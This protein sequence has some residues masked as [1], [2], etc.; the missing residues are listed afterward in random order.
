[1][2]QHT[3]RGASG[4]A[5]LA[6]LAILALLGMVTYLVSERN[7]HTWYL[8]PDEGRLVVMKGVFLP[9]GRQAF[10][11]A[12]P[13]LAQAYAPVVVPPGKAVP[14]ERDFSDQTGL[15]QALYDD[16]AG[17]AREDI[18]S[19]DPARLERALGYVDRADHLTGISQAQRQDLAALRGESG[20]FEA[21]RLLDKAAGDLRDAAEKLRLAA[22]SRSGHAMEAQVLLRDVETARDAAIQA[23]RAA[24]GNR[25]ADRAPGANPA[26]S[27]TQ[28]EA[29][30][31]GSPAPT[32][33]AP[34]A[35][36]GGVR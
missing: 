6:W 33:P 23:M 10:K 20:Y 31:A 22:G 3:Q 18:A 34:A 2:R 32:G 14:G 16:L 5:L 36:A 28:A 4:K 26:A 27:P 12:D 30:A 24:T 29:P 13:K 19:G 15:D 17:W 35:P 7:A 8:V 1:M 21:R 9:M 25:P 11:T